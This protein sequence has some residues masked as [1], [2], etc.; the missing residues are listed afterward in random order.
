MAIEDVK[1]TVS[2][3]KPTLT[4]MM[5]KSPTKIDAPNLS[6]M[7]KLFEKK[8]PPK[9]V[10]SKQPVVKE[11]RQPVEQ[12]SKETGLA[13]R[14]QNLSD[15]EKGLLAQLLSPSVKNVL[16]K[17]APELNPL[18]DAAPATEENVVIPISVAK[19]FANKNYGGQGEQSIVSFLNDLQNS[20]PGIT[21]EMDNKSVPPGTQMAETPES[22]V[23]IDQNLLEEG[24]IDEEDREEAIV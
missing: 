12:P 24:I 16:G 5:N 7:K 18:L 14:V 2:K 19:N 17:V 8:A 9:Q 10:A 11:E 13:E 20:A 3:G 21:N 22:G 1:G 4:G 15:E 23:D 6:G